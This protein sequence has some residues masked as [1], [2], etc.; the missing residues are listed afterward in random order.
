MPRQRGRPVVGRVI[1]KR[2]V[3][4]LGDRISLVIDGLDGRVHHVMLPDARGAGQP[5]LGA[6]VEVGWAS[7]ASPADRTIAEF[8]LGTGEYQPSVHRDALEARARP[9]PGRDYEAYVGAHVRRLEALRRTGIVERL[10]ADRWRIPEN[11][12][13]RAAEYDASRGT[14]FRVRVLSLPSTLTSK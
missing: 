10:D 9:V 2:L 13:A 8:A 6:I 7:S 11:F 5:D 3:D 4:E 14:S 1:D 12:E